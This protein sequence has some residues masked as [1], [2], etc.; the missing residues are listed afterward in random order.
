[1]FPGSRS[2][3][4]S[5]SLAQ[6]HAPNQEEPI[7]MT[8]LLYFIFFVSGATGL[9]YEVIWIR[10]TGLVF[11]NTSFSIAT[12]LGAFM[13]GLAMGSWFLGTF[14]DRYERPLKLY[15]IMEILIGVT[16]GL[17]PIAFRLTDNLYW[18]IAPNLASIPGADLFVR[19]SSSF[20][21]MLVPTFL[22][23][24]TL[25][26]LARFFVH[27]ADEV[28]SKLGAL[29]ALNTFG[30]AVGT[31]AAA[32]VLIPRL[33]TQDT[34]A[35]MVSLNIGLGLLAILFDP[36]KRP[37]R[38]QKVNRA[39]TV[40]VEPILDPSVGRLALLTLAVSGF[41]GMTYEVAWTR[42]LSTMISSSTYAFAIMLVTFLVGIALGS[43]W[44]SRFRPAA[45]IRMLG[46]VQLG[47]AI[48]GFV[49][50][51]GYLFAPYLIVVLIGVLDYSFPAVLTIQ[52][53][54]CAALMIVS[55]FFMGAVF[56][57]AGQLYSDR[58]KLM[59]RRIGG[60]Y[61]A[62]TVGAVLGSLSAGF[63]LVPLIGT[64]RTILTGLIL[65][66]A[67]AALLLTTQRKRLASARWVAI[68]LLLVSASSMR[69]GFFWNPDYLDRGVL[70]VAPEIENNPQLSIDNYWS[71]SDVVY[72]AE[73]KNANISVRRG[74]NYVGLRTNGKVDASNLDM[75]TQLLLA[76]LPGFHHPSPEKILVIGFGSGVT[77]GAATV[78]P[79]TVR[80]DCIE[81]ESAVL[82]AAPFF[83][84][85]NR[86]SYD[87]P[88]VKLMEGDARNFLNV[89][90]ESYDI[91]ISEPSNPWIAGVGSLFT[92]EFYALAASTLKPDGVFAQW[93]QLYALP[94]EDVQ[95]VLAEFQRQFPE[96]SIWDVGNNDLIILG[97]R[98]PLRMDTERMR[99]IVANDESVHRD[100]REH[101]ALQDPLGIFASFIMSSESVRQFSRTADRNTDDRP[102]LEFHAPRYLFEGTSDT[103]IAALNEY[104]SS[105]MPEG[106]P[107]S[108]RERAYVALIEPLIEKERFTAAQQVVSELSEMDRSED[109][110]LHIATARLVIRS[111]Q[112]A[113]AEESLRAAEQSVSES[114][115]YYAAEL[116]ELWALF[117]IRNGNENLAIQS[118]LRAAILDPAQ[119]S[120]FLQ[121]AG[122]Y[123]QSD[124]WNEA[125]LWME[126]FV[127]TDPYN[128]AI[129]WELL[130]EY[131]TASGRETEATTAFE[132]AIEEEPH[133]RLARLR[134]AEVM[135]GRGQSQ[136]AIE[137]LEFLSMRGIAS[138]VEVYT[139]LAGLYTSAG[140]TA[141][142]RNVLNKGARLFP[143]STEIE[144]QR[145]LLGI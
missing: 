57:I 24:G 59:G 35:W 58:M 74:I 141:D 122:L 54:V 110:S 131:L 140:H 113:Q 66:S 129:Y 77:T 81:I 51:I 136:E 49:F 3:C 16:A 116:Q 139:R 39:E 68:G 80:V 78:F 127:E 7:E 53:V 9:V 134:L 43:T 50:L 11:G 8:R 101:L 34:I 52:F 72:F 106:F 92:E 121:L 89:T 145:R 112:F 69:G 29:Y 82:G 133:M 107:D 28:E 76:Y 67:L 96:V 142:A 118:Y 115:G 103:N 37:K 108:V 30:A 26:V 12:V 97:S 128:V 86:E 45:S 144:E 31:L 15:G 90:E 40:D 36:G 42:A 21:I 25:P 132:T 56:P 14:A 13:A 109:V 123:A 2:R 44:A 73:G 85:L 60:I 130:G 46:M 102:L 70:V 93:L 4:D 65:N 22:M 6:T 126:R 111:D 120:Y 33:G 38:T 63:L 19:F 23:G 88:K 32:L 104:K 17:V 10:I 95:M 62:N 143:D 100:F 79:E 98:E 48:G 20:I 18:N 137:L 84:E 41:V 125:T 47:V 71:Q 64:E 87:H 99:R 75:A 61:S 138:N 105:L 94:L 55:T 117:H 124:Q 119:S 91:I 27:S 1:M 5:G 83:R 114:A 135:D